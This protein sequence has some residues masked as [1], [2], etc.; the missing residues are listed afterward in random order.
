MSPHKSKYLL[1]LLILV[2]CTDRSNGNGVVEQ[3]TQPVDL[4]STSTVLSTETLPS[5]T[6]QPEPTLTRTPVPTRTPSLTP[7]ELVC[8]PS[9]FGIGDS[10]ADDPETYVSHFFK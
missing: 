1:L 7:T 8:P 4:I 6:Q 5:P 2:S 10:A 3:A 9:P